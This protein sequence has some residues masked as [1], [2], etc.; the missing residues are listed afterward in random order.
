MAVPSLRR[1]DDTPHARAMAIVAAFA[2][3]DWPAGAAT[4]APLR[5]EP[6]DDWTPIVRLALQH[7]VS[8]LLARRA[9]TLPADLVPDE[10]R[11]AF[12][13]H[14][15]DN[16][17]RN[18]ALLQGLFRAM[19]ALSARCISA[20]PFKGQVLGACAF[21]DYSIRRAGD[22]DLLI[23]PR[24]RDATREVLEALGYAETTEREI[25]RTMTPTE[26]AVCH[27]YQCE[28]AMYSETDRV[29]VEPHWALAPRTL[30]VDPDYDGLWSRAC[31]V[32][33]RGRAVPTLAPDDLLVAL[34]IHGSKHE[35]VRLQ[36]IA[37][38]AAL[39][40]RHPDL[41]LGH[42]LH[43][44]RTRGLER[45]VLLGLGLARDLLGVPLPSVAD[46]RLDADTTACGLMAEVT[47]RLNAGAPVETS[48]FEPA[49]FR[50][51]MRE[52][53]RDRV[54]Y[55]VRTVTTPREVHVGLVPWVRLP[56]MGYVPVKLAHDYVA[57]PLWRLLHPHRRSERP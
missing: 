37:D 21:G 19:D 48:V 33:I 53:W 52:R 34:C 46:R 27:G 41:D 38:I 2:T 7:G 32:D 56:P 13:E 57:R 16:A 45:M 55:L 31:T 49:R 39:L 12:A 40:H 24:D 44:A 26:W 10:M 50:W 1:R 18:D 22:V 11:A 25:G 20:L 51:R 35:W 42:V 8:P 30:A 54:R 4:P 23:R 28:Y 36:W 15:D 5:T 6:I 3:P 9:Q 47:D 14:A 43:D 29:L 17:A